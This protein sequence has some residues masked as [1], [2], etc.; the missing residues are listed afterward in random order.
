MGTDEIDVLVL[1]SIMRE[2]QGIVGLEAQ[3]AAL[4]IIGAAHGAIPEYVRHEV[5]GLLFEP[6]SVAS[7]RAQIVRIIRDP[8][9]VAR[10]SSNVPAPQPMGV[11][12][13]EILRLYAEARARA[14]LE[15]TPA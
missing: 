8:G 12:V 15:R 7:L 3:A 6:G 11:H 2:T 14:G 5:T 1:P 10:L 9:L 13:R 4:P